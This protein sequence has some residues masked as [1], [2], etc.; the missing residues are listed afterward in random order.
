M[1]EINDIKIKNFHCSEHGYI[2]PIVEP[3]CPKCKEHPTP[4]PSV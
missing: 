3:K 4:T 2:K 1:K